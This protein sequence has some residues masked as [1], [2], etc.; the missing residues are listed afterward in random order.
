MERAEE[1]LGS[2]GLK[3]DRIPMSVF[4]TE[5]LLPGM[6]SLTQSEKIAAALDAVS[7]WI[8]TLPD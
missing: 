8:L 3:A 6:L 2:H 7:C 1:F 5:P 4:L